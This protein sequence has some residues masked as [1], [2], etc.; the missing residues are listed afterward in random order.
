VTQGPDRPGAAAPFLFGSGA[1]AIP[2]QIR[3]RSRSRPSIS[4]IRTIAVPYRDGQAGAIGAAVLEHARRNRAVVA[5]RNANHGS[6][7]PASVR[8]RAVEAAAMAFETWRRREVAGGDPH[9][10]LYAVRVP[11][12]ARLDHD[13]LVA[14]GNDDEFGAALAAWLKMRARGISE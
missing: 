9:Y 1:V 8:P 14:L 10:V 11:A 6:H 4:A 7:L 3:S 13:A 5:V 2:A 12:E